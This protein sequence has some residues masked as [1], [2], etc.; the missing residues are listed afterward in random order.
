MAERRRT[1]KI[2]D[3]TIV[4]VV[5]ES[6]IVSKERVVT[7]TVRLHKQVHEEEQV[8]EIPLQDEEIAVERV[9]ID[10]WVDEPVAVRHE[11]DTTV[12]PV[13]KEVLVYETRLKLVEE[14]RVTRRRATRQTQERVRLRRE[15]I[16]VERDAASGDRS[17]EA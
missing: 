13:L 1:E 6:A 2:V 14:V 7:E 8:L 5:E 17:R 10:R 12:Y 9:S 11:G 16:V 4:P 3:E 15:D